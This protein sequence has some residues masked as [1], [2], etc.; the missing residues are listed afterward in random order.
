[1]AAARALTFGKAIDEWNGS[2]R[3]SQLMPRAIYQ[4]GMIKPAKPSNEM[5]AAARHQNGQM[6]RSQ[7]AVS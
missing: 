5:L 4:P 2:I 6:I 1:M 7:E 3:E